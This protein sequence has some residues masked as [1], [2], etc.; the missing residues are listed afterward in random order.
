[1]RSILEGALFVRIKL[2]EEPSGRRDGPVLWHNILG[3]RI[4]RNAD[5]G[6]D[7]TIEDR[8]SWNVEG[9]KFKCLNGWM[10]EPQ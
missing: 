1:L 3:T 9:T 8:A 4:V 7:Y 2:E 6:P 5:S 10:E